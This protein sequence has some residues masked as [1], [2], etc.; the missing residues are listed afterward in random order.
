[1]RKRACVFV[2]ILLAAT[3]AWTQDAPSSQDGPMATAP[4][5][6]TLQNQAALPRPLGD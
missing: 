4:Q 2:L 5:S 1:M 3:A 6:P